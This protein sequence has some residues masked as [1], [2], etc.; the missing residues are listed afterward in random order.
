[1]KLGIYAATLAG[2]EG[3]CLIG[4]HEMHPKRV[5]QQT[6]K[7]LELLTF[8]QFNLHPGDII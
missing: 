6:Q 1:M 4:M 3:E 7:R 2:I 8:L 5:Y